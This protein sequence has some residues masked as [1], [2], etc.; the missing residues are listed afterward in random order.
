MTPLSDRPNHNKFVK[1][2]DGVDFEM[3]HGAG[4]STGYTDNFDARPG[5]SVAVL[6]KTRSSDN[7]SEEC[8]RELGEEDKSVGIYKSTRITFS[9]A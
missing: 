5:Y 3:G 1:S 2:H 9:P 4:G 8:L 6:G 7:S